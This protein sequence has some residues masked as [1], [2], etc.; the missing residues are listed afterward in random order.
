MPDMADAQITL[1]GAMPPQAIMMPAPM[2]QASR[3]VPTTGALPSVAPGSAPP[4]APYGAPTA[5]TAPPQSAGRGQGIAGKLGEAV[6]AI[7]D[8]F[9]RPK[10]QEAK[11]EDVR[12]SR[13]RPAEPPTPPRDEKVERALSAF[14]DALAGARR[15]LEAGRVPPATPLDVARKALLERLAASDLGTELPALQRFLR[16]AAVEIVAALAAPGVTA[17]QALE[18]FDRHARAFEEARA[19][20]RAKLGSAPPADPGAFWEGSV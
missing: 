7:A 8:L 9:A 4:P 20:A 1:A 13:R 19:E 17:A 5:P 12:E 10:R 16:S 15:E 3:S 18:V 11:R 6:D 14:A 2:M